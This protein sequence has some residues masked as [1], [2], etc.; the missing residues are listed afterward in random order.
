MDFS[1]RFGRSRVHPHIVGVPRLS[2]RQV[3]DGKRLACFWQIAA[4]KK[5]VELAIG[6]HHAVFDH[7]LSLISEPIAFRSRD[8]RWKICKWFQQSALGRIITA[9]I[10]DLLRHVAERNARRSDAR[11]SSFREQDYNLI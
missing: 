1:R 3:A 8:F 5:F 4:Y 9:L 10:L 6:W 2:I 11:L 7:S